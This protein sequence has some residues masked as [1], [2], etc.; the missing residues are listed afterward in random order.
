MRRRMYGLTA[1][2][3]IGPGRMIATSTVRSSSERG[4]TR[5]SVCI[6]ARD[7]IWN[8]PIVSAR[9]MAS[10]TRSSR[11]A[12]RGGGVR[13]AR[14]ALAQP[15]QLGG[16]QAQRLAHLAD[17]AADAVGGERGHQPHVLAAE[18]LV[19]AKD[20]LLPDV[21][22]EVEGDLRHRGHLLVEE[23]SQEEVVGDGVDVREPD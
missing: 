19:D 10:Y 6:C 1:P 16:G 11:E 8:T 21:A 20:Q 17:G 23:A 15:V 22:G 3:T 4:R 5:G 18:V 9:Q 12:M 2:P 13:F 14:R 7:S